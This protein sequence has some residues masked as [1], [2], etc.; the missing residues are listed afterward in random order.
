MRV[1]SPLLAALVIPSLVALAPL[2]ALAADEPVA[3]AAKAKK[4]PSEQLDDALLKDLDNELLDGA[5]D[6]KKDKPSAAKDEGEAMQ[7]IDG[8]DVGQPGE[9]DDPL[10]RVSQSMRRAERLIP[11]ESKRERATEVQQQIVDEL[12]K[13]I[14][15]AEK[16]SA[17]QAQSKQQQSQKTAKRQ[18]VQQPKPAKPGKESN[19]P[20]QD[21]TN[22]LGK[23]E[24][25]RPD[26]AAVKNMLKDAWGHLPAHAREQMLQNSP[27]RFL[28]QY[29]L[30]IEQY[31]KRL[32]EE[33]RGR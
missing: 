15:E 23:A 9:N 27:E 21:S 30:L 31:Y 32:A 24:E 3:P 17:Q 11:Q 18:L 33:Q 10:M 8:E 28:P 6:L 16:R 13:L 22:R 5:G 2:A 12:A 19:K 26:P 14:D 1:F 29:E 4:K 25:A 7:P 20:A